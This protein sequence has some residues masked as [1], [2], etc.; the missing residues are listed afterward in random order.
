VLL[1]S[2]ASAIL[3]NPISASCFVGRS[4]QTVYVPACLTERGHRR[5]T[6]VKR[7]AGLF[8]ASSVVLIMLMTNSRAIMGE[9]VNGWWISLAG[10]VTTAASC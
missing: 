8:D 10:W 3:A 6:P 4:S 5:R 1:E 2:T 9:R 7:G